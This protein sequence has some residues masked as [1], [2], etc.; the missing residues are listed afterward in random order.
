MME[1]LAQV[2]SLLC[3]CSVMVLSVFA[4]HRVSLVFA[5]RRVA[6]AAS[7]NVDV[8]ACPHVTVQ[9]PL[10]NEPTVARRVIE[11]TCA[12]DWPLSCFDVQV[13]DDSTDDTCAIVDGAV[14][15]ARARG[16]S[17]VVL[18]RC[19][20][21]GFKAGALAEGLRHAAGE[22][23]AVFDADFV[24]QS[25]FLRALVPE[26]RD[27][28]VGL[29]QARWGHLNR[30]ASLLTRVQGLLLDAHFSVEQQ[31][32][33]VLGRWFNFNG[34]AGIW[35]RSCIDDAG[36]WCGDTL[37]EDVD[38]SYR[39]QLKGWRFV[40]RN[41]VVVPAELP[42]SMSA[43]LGQQCRWMTGLS[44]VARKLVP[45]LWRADAPVAVK[46]EA[47]FHLLAPLASFA[48]TAFAATLPLALQGRGFVGESV[49]GETPLLLMGTCAAGV[50]YVAAAARAGTSVVRAVSLLP[51]L[52]A[53]GIGTAPIIASR[54]LRAQLAKTGVS[55][56]R[57]PK[58]GT[59]RPERA[60]VERHINQVNPTSWLEPALLLL[61]C[62]LAS[63]AVIVAIGAGR[64][65]V[66]V[67]FVAL[68]AWGMGW[69][70]LSASGASRLRR[71]V[72]QAGWQLVCDVMNRRTGL[73]RR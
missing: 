58:R 26:L 52:F 23:V 38:L 11:A 31:A 2:A 33:A 27:P 39:A 72:R 4:V 45:D 49:V 3:T 66:G 62:G 15:E 69:V 32:R 60:L 13:L 61:W 56:E 19:G 16:V 48:A 71:L 46:L 65:L 41:D 20:R 21:R 55:F 34:T 12:L 53:L 47:T 36:G 67:V 64:T 54:V 17:I 57:T 42:P 37:S 50:F 40:Y 1:Q 59:L 7:P 30:D 73:R 29:V 68:I 18:R 70:G 5:V 9:L 25:N 14:S 10:F 63:G 43:Y 24:P 44:Q 35:R 8:N 22:L 6:N 51:A 28:S